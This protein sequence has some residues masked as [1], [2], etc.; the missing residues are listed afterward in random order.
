MAFPFFF[1]VYHFSEPRILFYLISLSFLVLS[2]SDYSLNSI[3]QNF[4]NQSGKADYFS[5]EE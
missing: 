5:R 2:L 1:L 4:E 3:L